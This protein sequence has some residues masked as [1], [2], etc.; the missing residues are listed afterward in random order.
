MNVPTVIAV[1]GGIALLIG[2][3]GGGV[4]AKEIEIP[5]INA[6]IR[7][8][9]T[10]TGV[11]L[12][13]TAALLSSP[14]LLN[15]FTPAP[16]DPTE[17]QSAQLNENVF[18]QNF[19]G[20]DGSFDTNVWVCPAGSC[21]AQNVFQ[22]NGTLVFKFNNLEISSETWG[23]F[24][25]SE[26]TWK[27]GNLISLE[28]KLQI[29]ANTKGGTWLG[30]DG[31]SACALFAKPDIDTPSV[32]CDLGSDGIT[33]YTTGDFPVEFDKWYLIRIDYDP[34]TQEQKYHLDNK[35]IGQHIPKSPP[36]LT[37]VSLG[38]WR[39]QNQS[40]DAYIDNVVVRSRP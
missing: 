2:I 19:D 17:I 16:K 34:V 6:R 7:V 9:S 5:L 8:F 14:E 1:V 39:E 3:F 38:T 23:V 22:R 10:I 25:K 28:G 20:L 24:M 40:V 18:T 31:S 33:E 12:I 36:D 13:I 11:I 35:L 15:A 26:A 30:L 21:N 27:M 32:H 29:D 37:S 4:K